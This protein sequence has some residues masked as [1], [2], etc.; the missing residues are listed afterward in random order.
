MKIFLLL[1]IV[2]IKL[3][4]T[5]GY[6]Q[7]Y[8]SCF[9]LNKTQWTEIVQNE[10]PMSF[11]LSIHQDTTIDGTKYKFLD[12]SF[13]LRQDS[14]NSK[15]YVLNKE[16]SNEEYLIM[17][18][19]LNKG[20][21][22]KLKNPLMPEYIVV[23]SVYYLKERKIVQFNYFL[24]SNYK[25]NDE[26]FKFIEGIG[27]NMGI[28]YPFDINNHNYPYLLCYQNDTYN[29]ISSYYKSC[30][31]IYDGIKNI[32][33]PNIKILNNPAG[34]YLKLQ[35]NDNAYYNLTIIGINGILLKSSG[36]IYKEAVIDMRS[37][38]KGIYILK[39]TDNFGKIYIEK[40]LKL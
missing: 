22:F 24:W 34:D 31:Y 40:V 29:Y 25:G 6:G 37:F 3:S 18:L 33:P 17:D 36:K 9:G 13:A 15:L 38:N 12:Y 8:L 35:I 2:F 28:T 4:S 16:Y 5:Y 10:Y 14:L 27:S 1:S 21:T 39:L 30:D 23:D 26:K 7:T 20:D 19:T 32:Q 11:V